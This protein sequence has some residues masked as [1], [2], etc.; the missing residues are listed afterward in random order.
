VKAPQTGQRYRVIRKLGEGGTAEVYLVADTLRDGERLALKLLRS[1]DDAEHLRR[2]FDLLAGLRHPNVA[3]VLDLDLVAERPYVT[4]ELVDGPD[5]AAWAEGRSLE[6][7]VRALAGVLRGLCLLHDRGWVHGDLKPANVLVGA[8]GIPKLVDLGMAV[9]VGRPAGG[10]AGYIAPELLVGGEA[11]PSSDLYSF[12]A[13]AVEVLCGRRAFGD[14][15][16]DAVRR[17]LGGSEGVVRLLEERSDLAPPLSELLR[18]CVAVSPEDRPESAADLLE[19]L[20]QA[21]GI[22]LQPRPGELATMPLPKLVGRERELSRLGRPIETREHAAFVIQG[23]QGMGKS[24]LLAETRRLCLCGG[25]AC[26][27]TSGGELRQLLGRL[28]AVVHE[29]TALLQSLSAVLVGLVEGLEPSREISTETLATRFRAALSDLVGRIAARRPVA[30]LIDDLDLMDRLER[31]ALVGVA[32]AMVEEAATPQPMLFA[33]TETSPEPSP[34]FQRLELGPLDRTEGVEL[35]ASMLPGAAIPRETLESLHVMAAGTPWLLEET[36]RVWTA[37]AAHDLGLRD[38]SYPARV[39]AVARR[40]LDGLGQPERHLLRALA[41]APALDRQALRTLAPEAALHDLISRRLV[42]ERPTEEGMAVMLAGDHL[43]QALLED[44][45]DAE[46]R[47]M[48][49]SVAQ[50]LEAL[51]GHASEIARHLDGAGARVEAAERYLVAAETDTDFRGRWAL[52]AA[53]LGGEDWRGWAEAKRH[54]VRS[55]RLAGELS[56]AAAQLRELEAS[57]HLSVT[58]RLDLAELAVVLGQHQAA[59]EALRAPVIDDPRA[60]LI[61][62]R[63]LLLAGRHDEALALED[64]GEESAGSA[65][66]RGLVFHARG[67]LEHAAKALQQAEALYRAAGDQTGVAKVANNLAMVHQARGEV[68]EARRW[69]QA[70]MERASA[71]GDH[72][73]AV[74]CRM[75]HGT[76][77]Q[78]TGQF[79]RALDDYGRAA[80]EARRLGS[81]QLESQAQLNLATLFLEIG[82]L[83]RAGAALDRCAEG[84]E[85]ALNVLILLNR[86]ELAAAEQRYGDARGH[87][88]RAAS[89]DAS[90]ETSVSLEVQ[91]AG[92]RLARAQGQLAES[93]RLARAAAAQASSAGFEQLRDEAA[94]TAAVAERKSPHSALPEVRRELEQAVRRMEH[95]GERGRLWMGYHELS[96]IEALLGLEIEAT[97]HLAKAGRLVDELVE[98]LPPELRQALLGRPE[99]RAVYAATRSRPSLAG[100]GGDRR[101]DSHDMLRINLELARVRDPAELVVLILDKAIE[102]TGAQRGL[103]LLLGQDDELRI[104]AARNVDQESL[105]QGG[106]HF[107]KGLAREVI[108]TGQAL[109][110][111]DAQNDERFHR[112]E[113]VHAMKLRSVVCTPIRV[114]GSIAGV[115]YLDNRYRP[116][117]FTPAHVSLLEGFGVQAGLALDTARLLEQKERQVS[118]LTRANEQVKQ[119]TRK[120]KQ[121]LDRKTVDL[122]DARRA[123]QAQREQQVRGGA[124]AEIVGGSA[125]IRR[126]IELVQKTAH[127]EIPVYI[128]GESGTGKELVARAIH[129][130]SPRSTGPLVTL[131]CGALSPQL[132]ASELFGHRKGAFTGAVRDHPGLIRAAAGGTLFLDEVTEMSP[133]LQV[134]LLRVL[135]TGDFRAVGGE[136][137]LHADVRIISASN[138]DLSQAVREGRFREDLSYRLNVLRLDLAPLR[139]R[140]EDIPSLVRHFLGDTPIHRDALARLMRHDWPGNVRELQN[141]LE[142]ARALS[143]EEIRVVDLSSRLLAPDDVALEAG[144]TLDRRLAAFERQVLVEALEATEYSASRAAEVLGL[145]RAGLYKKMK[146]YGIEGRRSKR[147]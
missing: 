22:D 107:S 132:L 129:Q 115:V 3:T 53:E 120:L 96:Q 92:A 136:Q 130:V 72:L 66:I 100:D 41:L 39:L 29:E 71:A 27:G 87:L 32:R 145:S 146:R 103:V 102:L 28:A 37:A 25:Y 67:E 119:L 138:R 131:N 11:T 10:T 84:A 111:V 4:F 5:L 110:T 40:R 69:Y 144:A 8:E 13:V 48:H 49:E 19:R 45:P 18:R 116:D 61:Q 140:R 85:G 34:G 74:H 80:S 30:I 7:T 24:R 78:M 113:S 60:R 15:A 44:L 35:L 122:E 90:R 114:W 76:V 9:R 106:E 142:R 99:F 112:F 12:G 54:A 79:A 20:Q 47:R 127:T 58:D 57:P 143:Q 38:L 50:A 124:F 51:G 101:L 46:Q 126:T 31:E 108:A 14:E 36:L 94:F 117:A 118:E 6:E 21:T 59:L 62:A 104:A 121:A 16:I 141:E 97:F 95:R 135:Q 91:L 123:I 139:E 134:Q 125:P 86:A 128:F 17:Q 93:A 89:L 77:C 55:L 137:E 133:E 105:S 75:N 82:D 52:R 70:A 147:T 33:F 64:K 42:R 43:R 81:A 98:D 68:E 56:E 73:R 26:F 88:D 63:A 83:Q 23:E 2:E 109:L 1:R 65:N